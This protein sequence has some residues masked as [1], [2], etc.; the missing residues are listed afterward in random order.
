MEPSTATL[1]KQNKYNLHPSFRF[2]S[3]LSSNLWLGLK[4]G[5]FASAIPTETWYAF[6]SAVHATWP[7]HCILL[8]FTIVMTHGKRY[9]LWTSSVCYLFSSANWNTLNPGFLY[10][11]T[12]GNLRHHDNHPRQGNMLKHKST[13]KVPSRAQEDHRDVKW[14]HFQDSHQWNLLCNYRHSYRIEITWRRSRVL[15]KLIVCSPSQEIPCLLWNPKVH[16]RAS[17]ANARPLTQFP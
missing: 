7:G 4:N 2:I 1:L 5:L 15:E 9:K 11:T 14:L 16:N 17:W 6:V 3:M 13:L 10:E 12:Y 8:H